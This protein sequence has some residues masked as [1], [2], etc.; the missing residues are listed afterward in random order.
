MRSLGW[1]NSSRS[2]SKSVAMPSFQTPAKGSCLRDVQ[3]I[4]SRLILVRYAVK[5][6]HIWDVEKEELLQTVDAPWDRIKD[7]RISGDGSKVFCMERNF[8]HAWYIWTGEVMGGVPLNSSIYVDTFLTM[9]SSKVWVK[10]PSQGIKGWDFGVLDP[11]SIKQCAGPCHR[12]RFLSRSFLSISLM[13]WLNNG[14]FLQFSLCFPFSMP[15]PSFLFFSFHTFKDI[16]TVVIG[17]S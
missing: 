9:D 2:S 5:R 14:L 8:I 7:L 13:F 17:K 11:S 3:L 1:K 6:I 12:R 10:F 4:E 15:F 16:R